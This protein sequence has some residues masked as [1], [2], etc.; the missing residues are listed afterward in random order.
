MKLK[1]TI[2]LIFLTLYLAAFSQKTKIEGLVV[3]AINNAPLPFA[4][5][6]VTGTNI[7]ATTNIDGKF[8][9]E[10]AKP[11]YLSLTATSVGFETSTTQ[12][13]MVSPSKIAYVEIS[14]KESNLQ[15]EEVEVK[16]SPFRRSTES[17]VSLRSI[18]IEEIERNPGGNRDISRI[19]Q[20]YPGVASTP[21]FRNDVIVRGGGASENRFYL[22]DV[23]IPN[24]NHFATQGASGGPV[25]IINVDFIREVDFYSGAFPANHGNA[26]SS[27]FEFKQKDGNPDKQRFRGTIGASDLALTSDGPLHKNASYILS[28]RRSYLQFLFELLELPFLPTYNDYQ[29]KY[30]WRINE[31]NELSIISIGALDQF[32]LNKEANETEEQRFILNS[33]AVQEQWNYTAGIVYK[34]FY[35]H[36]YDTWVFSRNHLNNRAHKYLN[37]D[38]SNE[39]NKLFDYRSD[40]IENKLRFEHQS[41]Y[42]NGVSYSY[43][44]NTEWAY[45]GNRTFQKTIINQ[46][47]ETINYTNDLSLF[48]YGTFGQISHSFFERRL[49]LSL[50]F[51]FDGS[52]YSDDMANLLEQFS[53]R[54]SASYLLTEKVS[55]N[56]NTGRYYQ[57]PA[58]TTLAFRNNNN[59][60]VNKQN[61]LRY[62]QSDHLVAGIGYLPNEKARISLEGFYKRYADYPF[63]VVDSVAL[64]SKTVDFGVFGDEEVIPI[65][66]GRAY[67]LELMG[68]L[69]AIWNTNATLSYTLVRSEFKD[70]D[71]HY[72]PSSWDNKHLFTFTAT[73]DFP[74]NWEVGMKWRFVAGAPYTPYDPTSANRLIWDTNSGAILD[75][76]RFNE[77]RL[78]A[79]HQLDIRIDKQYY[80]D[81]WSLM[82]YLDIQN[83]YNF[84]SDTAPVLVNED[85]NGNPVIVNPEVQLQEQLYQLREL[86]TDGGGT[87]LPTI[88]I[89]LEF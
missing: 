21:N 52:N 1:Y 54:F 44:L 36:G 38:D 67:G 7:G 30:R 17:P 88:G 81:K 22:D 15:I 11:G 85:G 35:K 89:M 27:V 28:V 83:V 82:V 74:K 40:E 72:V 63:S 73:R 87:I 46:N 86:E 57:R 31:K 23:E 20:S 24:L 33:I 60:L 53:P 29:F 42:P 77:E 68:E 43:G 50:G 9:I 75:Y 13:F 70:I 5:V 56:F 3:N 10:G 14:L 62:I 51:R 16:A 78:G 26:L 49:A 58:Y 18:G 71:G 45:F 66:E 79:F 6:I 80:F 48:N 55:V 65:G 84:K 76:S 47:L 2:L 4:N 34:H 69:K 12:R 8:V 61:K 19:I 32:E 59:E 41:R 37:H 39:D 25:G 64:A